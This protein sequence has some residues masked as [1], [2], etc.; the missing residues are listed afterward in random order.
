MDRVQPVAAGRVNGT[1]V[2]KQDAEQ[3]GLV[4]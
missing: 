1:P 4:I 3:K 2:V